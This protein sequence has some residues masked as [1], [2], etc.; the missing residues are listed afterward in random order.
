[1]FSRCAH[2]ISSFGKRRGVGGTVA[3][4]LNRGE[5]FCRSKYFTREPKLALLRRQ[6]AVLGLRL[7][8]F[9]SPLLI[10]KYLKRHNMFR[11]LRRSDKGVASAAAVA[12]SAG[13]TGHTRSW[14][15]IP[16]EAGHSPHP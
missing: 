3:W 1:M 8:R 9:G 11:R 14:S 16:P 7:D 12:F 4:Q 2:A 10:V 13:A 6:Q 5:L 15:A